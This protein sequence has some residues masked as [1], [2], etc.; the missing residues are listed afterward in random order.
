MLPEAPFLLTDCTVLLRPLAP[1][2]VPAITA[3][4][5]DPEIPRWTMVPSPYQRH[6]AEKFLA[7]GEW[8]LAICLADA[9]ASL[10]GC[11]GAPRADEAAGTVE[12]GYWIAA[13]ARGRGLA[14]AALG[15]VAGW[16]L[17]ECGYRRVELSIFPG[18]SASERVAAKAGFRFEGV[19]PR[20]HL[21]DGVPLDAVVWVLTAEQV[22]PS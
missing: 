21:R 5:Q 2:D 9:P 16:F 20:R 19:A 7:S 15:L 22:S 10:L 11:I 13:P 12:L 4:C 1:G 17:D 14:P 3:A 6:D 18:N 8:A